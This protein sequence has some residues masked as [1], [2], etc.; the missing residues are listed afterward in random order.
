MLL[1]IAW[2]WGWCIPMQYSAGLYLTYSL[3]DQES[4]RRH[5]S[6]NTVTYSMLS[7][8]LFYVGLLWI[9][10]VILSYYPLSREWPYR[11]V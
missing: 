4:M 9:T 1:K 2:L 7:R 6:G 3:M 10:L 8:D 11:R 5:L